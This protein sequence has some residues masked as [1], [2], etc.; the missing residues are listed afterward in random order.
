MVEVKD[1]K[2][3]IIH[4]VIE[5]HTKFLIWSWWSRHYLHNVNGCYHYLDKNDCENMLHYLN[6]ESNVIE[7]KC[8]FS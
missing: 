7:H 2:S 8:Y 4:Y 3:S 6:K 1:N 5:K